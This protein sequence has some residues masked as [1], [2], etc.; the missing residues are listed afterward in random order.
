M[1]VSCP[2]ALRSTLAVLPLLLAAGCAHGAIQ[3]KSTDTIHSGVPWYDQNNHTVSAH[4]AGIIKEGDRFYL[5]GEFKQDHGNTFNGFSCYSSTDLINWKLEAIALPVQADGRLGPDRV[6]E[7]PKV[8]KCPKTGEFVMFMHTDDS[9]YT[10]PAVGYA[11]SPT[12]NGTYTFRGPLLFDGKPVK[13][14]DMGVFQDDDGTGYLITHSGNLYKLADDY[15]SITG[16]IVK[17]MTPA[18]EAPAIFKHNGLYYWL[19]SSLTGWERNDNYYF[20]AKSLAGPWENRGI[21]A[22]KDT[23]T[24]NSQTTFVLPIIG[25]DTTTWMFMGDRWAHPFQNSAATYVWQP[26]Q[27]DADGKTSLPEFI[28]SLKIDIRTGHWSP[29]LPEGKL[30]P[31]G[32]LV[33]PSADWQPHTDTKGFTDLRSNVKGA[34]LTIP[35]TGT[36]I[37]LYSVAR[38]DGGFGKVQIKDAKGDIVLTS[39]IDTYCHYREASLKFL[40]PK[41]KKDAYILT[42]SVL[43]ERFYSVGKRATYGSTDDYVSVQKL[44]L[45]E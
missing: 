36:Q 43:G 44:F 39:I 5:F 28:P 15:K 34:V 1:S 42:V 10:D 12:I 8:M 19:G 22:P 32:E 16:H 31:A 18:C 11:T 2:A 20:T 6:G 30:I 33:H 26:L 7:R 37:G 9:R 23:L 41:L 17:D 35:F 27:F 25:S 38:P 13:K 24:W 3:Q 40:S 45:V 21:F 29:V 14:W 4:G